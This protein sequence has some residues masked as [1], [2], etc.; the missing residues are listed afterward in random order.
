MPLWYF[1]HSGATYKCHNLLPYLDNNVTAHKHPAALNVLQSQLDTAVTAAAPVPDTADT[2]AAPVP[3]TAVTA[4][5]PVP[6]TAVTAVAPVPYMADTAAAPVLDK[7]QQ[8]WSHT[9]W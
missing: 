1:C 5:A 2:A 3:D 8:E 6:E 4:A 7:L 9:D